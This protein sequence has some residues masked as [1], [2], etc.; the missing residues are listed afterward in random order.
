MRERALLLVCLMFFSTLSTSTA[1][2]EEDMNFQPTHSGVDY[3]VGYVDFD[4]QEGTFE[5]DHRLVY[6][7]L[8]SGEEQEMAGNGPFPWVLLLIDENESP[9]N[10]MLISTR[11]AQRGTMVYIHTELNSETNPTW[12]SL[13][14]SILDVQ[15]WMNAANQ[16]NDV[17]LGMFGSVDEKHWGLIGHG[18]GATWA[19]NVYI[20]WD[21]LVTDGTLEPPRAL[22]GLAMQVESVQDPIIS[23][24][25]MPNVAL[26]ITGSADEVAPATE[27]VIPVLEN[28]DGLAWQILH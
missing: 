5:A 18:Y 28:V 26:Y 22:V 9:D 27:N 21:N 24:G 1:V 13:I 20:N 25:A 11:I 12:Q 16:T 2:P 7:A 19:S 3:P 14:E 10:Y 6:P 17:V 4:Q 23:S 8:Q 15:S